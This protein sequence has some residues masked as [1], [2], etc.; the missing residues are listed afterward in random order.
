MLA[1]FLRDL[2]GRPFE[3]GRTDCGIVIA[4]WLLATGRNRDAAEE[5]RGAYHDEES[6]AA[7]LKG[8]GGLAR[9]VGRLL[10]DVGLERVSKAEAKPGDVGVVRFVAS[11]G[12]DRH[13][14]AIMAP[15]GRWAVKC[16]DG[17]VL[18]RAP[19]VVAVWGVPPCRS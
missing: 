15:S 10:S 17:L 18:L 6:C 8:Q 9:L 12:V 3:Y 16:N 13:F 1:T 5:V 11:D 14:G 19:K 7:F 4:D 2:A